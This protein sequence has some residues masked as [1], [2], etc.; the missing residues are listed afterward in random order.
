MEIAEMDGVKFRNQHTGEVRC[1]ETECVGRKMKDRK[2]GL[3]V[4]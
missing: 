3:C 2:H 4:C 1:E